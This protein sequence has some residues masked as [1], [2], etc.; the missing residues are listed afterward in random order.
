MLL[1][2]RDSGPKYHQ[3]ADKPDSN[4]GDQAPGDRELLFI[5]DRDDEKRH[6]ERACVVQCHAGFKRQLAQRPEP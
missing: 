6:E 4:R 3:N 1:S 2:R 5:G